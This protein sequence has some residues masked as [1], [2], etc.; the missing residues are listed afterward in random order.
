MFV[1]VC[2]WDEQFSEVGFFFFFCY[3]KGFILSNKLQ[4]LV[5]SSETLYFL[6]HALAVVVCVCV[7]L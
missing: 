4:P 6:S 3:G 1:S 2:T 7:I 5:P